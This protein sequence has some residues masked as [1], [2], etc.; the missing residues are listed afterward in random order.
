MIH[1]AFAEPYDSHFARMMADIDAAAPSAR[2]STFKSHFEKALL[3]PGEVDYFDLVS[4]F[5]DHARNGPLGKQLGEGNLRDL[6]EEIEFNVGE[7][8]QAAFTKRT[9]IAPAKPRKALRILSVADWDGKRVPE[10]KF[11]VPGMIPAGQPCLM[12]G[13]GATGKSLL[14][15]QLATCVV[16]NRPWL[17]IENIAFGPAIYF[18]AE[19]DD[20]ELHRRFDAIVGHY[21]V[22][23][24]QLRDLHVIPLAGEDAVLAG[25]EGRTNTITTTALWRQLED[26]IIDIMPAVVVLDVLADLFSG[27]ENQRAQARQFIGLLRGLCIQ[28]GTTIIALAHPSQEGMRSGSGSSGSTGWSNSVRSRL[29][30]DRVHSKEDGGQGRLIERDETLREL[31]V[32][33]INYGKK[34]TSIRLRWQDGVFVADDGTSSPASALLNSGADDAFMRLLRWHE[35][36]GVPVGMR[37]SRTFAPLVFSKHPEAAGYTKSAF[38]EA[39]HRLLKE[40]RI[41]SIVEGPPSK[42]VARLTAYAPP[43][44]RA[45]QV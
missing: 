5:F 34:G 35:V 27:D 13:D 17:G 1:V 11:V 33:K 23:L 29:Y 12:M 18:S 41:W 38:K 28:Y 30:L 9:G 37:D 36:H 31:S 20:D 7:A 15:M 26:A 3:W 8:R 25:P 16:L 2:V 22:T 40:E 44:N 32:K 45:E 39:M 10:R 24:K 6:I 19:D 4:G 42:Q 14:T 43:P 21:G